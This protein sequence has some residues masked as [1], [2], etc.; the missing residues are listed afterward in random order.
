MTDLY[1]SE[2]FLMAMEVLNMFE[3]KQS[4]TVT[5]L[6]WFQKAII[7]IKMKGYA[8]IC[9]ITCFPKHVFGILVRFIN[10]AIFLQPHTCTL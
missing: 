6:I 1:S 5:H 10:R 3:N 9:S 7:F 4:Y 2:Q 8:F